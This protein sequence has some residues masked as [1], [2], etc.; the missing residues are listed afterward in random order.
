[1]SIISA[2]TLTTTALQLTADTAGTLVF[3]TGAT[4]TTALTLNADQSAT[5]AGAVNFTTAGF[6]NLS[7]SG[8]LTFT[9]TGNRITGDFSNATIANR[10]LLQSSTSNGQ[11]AVGLIP[12]GT[13]TQSQFIA[14]N[15]TDPANSSYIQT[16]ISNTEARINSGQLG[17]GTNLPLTMFT[18]G[19]ERL[20]IDTSGN[21]G[22]GTNSPRF[23]LSIGSITAVSTA[24]PDTIDLGATFSSTA[25]ANPKLRLFWDG[26]VYMG[27]GISSNQ[28]DYTVSGAYSHVWYTNGSERMRI[29]S[30]GIIGIGTSSPA[31]DFRMTLAGDDTINPGLVALNN[32]TG[33]QVS[34]TIYASSSFGWTGTR[35]NHPFILITNGSERFRFGTAGQFGIGGANYG[36]AGQVLVSGG[37]GAAPSW[38]SAVSAGSIIQVVQA[39]KTDTQSFSGLSTSWADITGLSVTIT[40]RN[41]SSRFIITGSVMTSIG[42]NPVQL[43]LVRNGSDIF[44]GDAAGSR[45]RAMVQLYGAGSVFAVYTTTNYVDSPAT[46]SAITYKWQLSIG[47]TFTDYVNRCGRDQ[48]GSAE[49]ARGASNIVVMEIA[50]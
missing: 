50:G 47:G 32:Q 6:T 33:T 48:D 18:G 14:F 38:G 22:I 26:G 40:P 11:T 39:T 17:T 36:T 25:G 23:K 12:N 42:G 34:A 3:R 8:N 19:S 13:S 43:K 24:T 41:S 31:G 1:M 2:S 35:S 46:A 28:L 20:R 4:P 27:L 37:S 10:V 5:F 44:V 30:T 7:I 21:V 49:D 15:S 16:L 45:K 9:S 29:T